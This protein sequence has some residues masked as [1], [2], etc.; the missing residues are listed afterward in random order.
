M[1]QV[2]LKYTSSFSSCYCYSN[3]L[4][5]MIHMIDK[6]SISVGACDFFIQWSDSP[7]RYQITSDVEPEVGW[8]MLY[9]FSA[10]PA[11]QYYILEKKV[12][13]Q[14]LQA[15]GGY[16]MTYTLE[17]GPQCFSR[18]DWR[19]IGSFYAFD[20]PLCGST[21]YTVYYRNDPFP[22]SIIAIGPIDKPSEWAVK[23]WFYAFDFALPGTCVFNLQHCIRSIHSIA[24]SLTRHRLTVE[25]PRMPWEFRMKLY[26]FP[27]TLDNISLV[28]YNIH[29]S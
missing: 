28:D 24:A 11:A 23:F 9:R 8:R 15:E 3:I 7:D 16:G 12:Y 19:L 10:Y 2:G 13:H 21:K 29:A 4:M 5:T 14:V 25:D 6:S 26:V 1:C 20:E 18:K 27:V 17:R 22:R